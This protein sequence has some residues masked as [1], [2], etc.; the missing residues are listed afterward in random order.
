MTSSYRIFIYGFGLCLGYLGLTD[1]HSLM[2]QASQQ[3]DG[4]LLIW[5]IIGVSLLGLID[6]LVNR[7]HSQRVPCLKH[8]R[9]FIL[10][11]LAFCFLAMLYVGYSNIRSDGVLIFYLWPGVCTM[12]VAL[13]DARKR[14]GEICGLL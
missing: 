10:A 5:A 11:G 6:V 1:S 12:G 3:R 4:T 13:L 14:K 9:H 7:S 2:Y 8:H